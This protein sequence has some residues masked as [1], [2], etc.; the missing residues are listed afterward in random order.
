VKHWVYVDVETRGDETA[1]LAPVAPNAQLRDP[2]KIARDIAEKVAAAEQARSLDPWACRIGALA[3]AI[4]YDRLTTR[5]I[6]TEAQERT[7]LHEFWM[8]TGNVVPWG[9]L[10][11]TL[12]GFNLLAFDVRVL[13]VRSQILGVPHPLIDT[14]PWSNRDVIDLYALL[15]DKGDRRAT[16]RT[17]GALCARLKVT[18]EPAGPNVS[19]EQIPALLDEG[20]E[21]SL[22]IV[23]AHVEHDVRLVRALAARLGLSD[24]DAHAWR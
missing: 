22:A 23:R 9:A 17:L 13:V 7:A 15:C 19:G 16:S 8:A 5:L 3:Y 14:R 4:G 1:P 11:C 10:G 6:T 2:E 24:P 18:V 20:S 12:V 21:A